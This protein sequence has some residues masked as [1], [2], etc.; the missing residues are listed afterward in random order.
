MKLFRLF[1]CVGVVIL[2]LAALELVACN[3]NAPAPSTNSANAQPTS[4]PDGQ[5]QSTAAAP[6]AAP[7]PAPTATSAPALSLGDPKNAVLNAFKATQTKSFRMRVEVGIGGGKPAAATITEFMAPDRTRTKSEG[8]D[9]TI[10]V[11]GAKHYQKQNGKWVE[12]KNPVQDI[13]AEAQRQIMDGLTKGTFD[14]KLIGADV[15]AGAPTQVYQVNGTLTVNKIT[16]KGT[17]K[18]WIRVIDGLLVK[19][20]STAEGG[21]VTAS[22]VQTYEYDPTIK[23]DAPIP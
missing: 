15:V 21:G 11:I 7:S 14:I 1:Q 16:M 9:W 17:N 5:A 12:T 4:A 3:T 8:A 23:I 22:T 20:E 10:I 18:L 19:Q 2:V 13:N 6:T